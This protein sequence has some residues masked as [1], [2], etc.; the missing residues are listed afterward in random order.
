MQFV[1]NIN[2][3]HSTNSKFS[4]IQCQVAHCKSSIHSRYSWSELPTS[5]FTYT[6]ICYIYIGKTRWSQVVA[7]M[8]GVA[9]ARVRCCRDR[10]H[11]RVVPAARLIASTI[12]RHLLLPWSTTVNAYSVCSVALCL[13]L[14]SANAHIQA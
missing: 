12:F 1:C 14:F 11:V 10:C 8:R 7:C 6:Y 5:E 13:F 9:W 3:C 2:F 4:F